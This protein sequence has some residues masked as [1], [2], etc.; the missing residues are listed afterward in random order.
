MSDI[1][2]RVD[3]LSK[4]YPEPAATQ[5]RRR[6]RPGR[7]GHMGAV[8]Q[9]PDTTSTVLTQSRRRLRPGSASLRDALTGMFRSGHQSTS[10]QSTNPQSTDSD[11]LRALKDVSFEACPAP[12]QSLHS[13]RLRPGCY[14]KP[15]RWVQRGE[16]VWISAQQDAC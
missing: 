9:R 14:A 2:I 11:D 8:H 12:L 7:A 16:V 10:S 6:L 15:S 4:L 3:N 5:S 1:A 13:F